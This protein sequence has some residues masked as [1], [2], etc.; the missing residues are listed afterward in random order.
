MS[1][2]GAVA[3]RTAETE[4]AVQVGLDGEG[5]VEA[6][7][8]VAF[9]DHL[10]AAFGRHA[11]FDLTVRAAGDLAVDAHHTV[12]DVGIVLGQAVRQAIGDGAGIARFASIHL[13]MDEALVLVALDVSGRSYLHFDVAFPADRVGAF[14]VD[15]VEEFLRAFTA[16]AGVTLHVALRHGRNTHHIA[17]AVFKGLGVALGRALARTGQG[18]PSTKGVL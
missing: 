3:R 5:R 18:V 10:L 7:T 15:L 1:R 6:A 2:T 17:E 8:G 4:V 9:F 16:H 14:P 12:E 11:R 13:P